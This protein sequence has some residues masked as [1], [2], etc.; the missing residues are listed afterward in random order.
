MKKAVVYASKLGRT[1]KTAEYIAKALDADLFDV[2]KV[3]SVSDYDLVVFGSGIYA[4]GISGPLRTFIES[5][6]HVLRGK[7]TAFFVC[8]RF[9]GEKAEAQLAGATEILGN[10][11]VSAYFSG[12]RKNDHDADNKLRAFIGSVRDII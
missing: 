11:L 4:G 3:R 7:R 2:K 6:L 12:K 5:D 8:C 9:D 10:T 1:R